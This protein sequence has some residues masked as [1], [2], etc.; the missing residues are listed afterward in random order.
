MSYITSVCYCSILVILCVKGV[1]P[2][3]VRPAYFGRNRCS[4]NRRRCKKPGNREICWKSLWQPEEAVEDL[5]IWRGSLKN[6][7][8]EWLLYFLFFFFL[9]KTTCMYSDF[10]SFPFECSPFGS[11]VTEVLILSFAVLGWSPVPDDADTR[12]LLLPRSA[13]LQP[14]A[15]FQWLSKSLKALAK[16][17]PLKTAGQT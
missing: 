14:R 16:V 11:V 10:N 13:G 1:M 17:N 2:A 9:S 8:I 7:I 12:L 15:A 3:G 5:S 4:A 6:I